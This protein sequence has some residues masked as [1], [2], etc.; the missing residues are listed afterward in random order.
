MRAKAAALALILGGIPSAG[1][2]ATA[3]TQYAAYSVTWFPELYVHTG[4]SVDIQLQDGEKLTA[5]ALVGDSRWI[6]TSVTSGARDTLHILV[7]TADDIP[8][9]QLLTIPTTGHQYHV[10]LRSGSRESSAYTVV[11]YDKPQIGAVKPTPK[12]ATIIS[13]ANLT[14][15]RYRISGDK[16]IPIDSVCDDGARTYITIRGGGPAVVPYRVD[17]GGKQDQLA[18]Y[19]F[20]GAPGPN[21]GGQYSIEG[22]FPRLA[23]LTDS[24][25]G[26][27]RA[28]IERVEQVAVRPVAPEGASTPR[29]VVVYGRTAE[30][31]DRP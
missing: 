6:T 25:R 30:R 2:A 8:D 12:P 16:R 5:S 28:N 18:N 22:T 11:F 9:V 29:P 15:T 1:L 27:I 23:L 3:Y 14:A 10:L 17:V 24:S 7:K 31:S 13:C 19:V 21:N 20:H 26:Q 4:S